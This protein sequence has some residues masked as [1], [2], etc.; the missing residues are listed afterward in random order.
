MQN[1]KGI[2]RYD[3]TGFSGWQIQPNVRTVQGEI[4]QALSRIASQPIR[5]QGAARTDA[6]VHALGQVFSCR[7]PHEPDCE[8]LRRS[9]SKMLGPEIR[10]ASMQQAAPD[11]HAR[12]S[13]VS[14]R[15]AYTLSLCREPDPFSA[16]YAWHIPWKIDVRR[17]ADLARR[18]VGTRDF[19]GFQCAG[20][21]VETTLRTLHSVE[22]FNGGVV[23]PCDA[24]DLWRLE[25][26]GDGFLYKMVRNITG[27]L[28]EIARG[29]LPEERLAERLDSPGPFHGHTAPAHGLTLIEVIY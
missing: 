7:W 1:L 22:L 8:R 17:L 26:C 2:V 25:F 20:A 19:A 21:S 13:A 14:K 28:I 24:R 9:V 18:L 3:G 5:V 29:K 6:G 27:V 10:V 12:F 11:F 4:E 23:D 15:Y 16:R